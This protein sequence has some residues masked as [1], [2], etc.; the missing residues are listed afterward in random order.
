MAQTARRTLLVLALLLAFAH[1]AGDPTL[2]SGPIGVNPA[3]ILAVNGLSA[4]PQVGGAFKNV[5]PQ[6][7]R[8]SYYDRLHSL[9]VGGTWL[10]PESRVAPLATVVPDLQALRENTTAATVTWIGHA[11]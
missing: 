2:A 1:S 8:A 9:I 10:V 5:D 11:T 7:K 4:A 6:Y 3:S